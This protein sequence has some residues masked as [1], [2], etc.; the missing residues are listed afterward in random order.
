MVTS[1]FQLSPSVFWPS[2]LDSLT[3]A[4]P[5]GTFSTHWQSQSYKLFLNRTVCAK[6]KMWMGSFWN[7]EICK[8]PDVAIVGSNAIVMIFLI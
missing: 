8:A 7:C 6:I 5:W 4:S 1:H 3:V 2:A